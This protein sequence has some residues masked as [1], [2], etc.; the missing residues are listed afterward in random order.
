MAVTVQEVTSKRDM[1]AFVRL[2]FRIYQGNPNWVPPL[3]MDDL[4][5]FDRRKNPAFDSADCKLFLASRDGR[6]VGRV[7]AILNHAANKKFSSRNLRFGW[8]EA[9]NDEEVA[10]ALF[11][12]VEKWARETG[13][14]SITGPH[15]FCDLDPQGMLVEGF[16]RLGTIAGIYNHSYYPLLLEKNGFVKEIDYVEFQSRVPSETGIPEKLVRLAERVK[17]RSGLR[18]LRFGSKKDVLKRADELFDVL[19]EAYEEIYG[20]VPL[21]RRQVKYFVGKYFSFVDKDLIK[22][23]VNDKDEMVGFMITMPSM[24]RAMQ[25]ARGRLL[26]FGWFHIMRA[27]KECEIL[28]FYLI[29]IRRAYRGLG[30]D[31]L[32]VIEIAKTALK[33]GFTLTESNQELETNTKVQAQWKYFDPVQHKRRRIFRKTLAG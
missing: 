13:M 20:A 12:A 29:G 32:M 21:T 17:E 5:T 16:D 2:P 6:P 33:K 28:D 14:N 26:P 18:V 7:A 19:D 15:G 10:S 11:A 30:V 1:R 23:V 3:I 25:K 24:S 4:S 9:E 27:F 8:F 22:A 31:L